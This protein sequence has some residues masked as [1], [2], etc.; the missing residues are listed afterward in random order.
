V[1]V[2]PVRALPTQEMT[3]TAEV[4][5]GEIQAIVTHDS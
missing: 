1:Y 3:A 5:L 2:E 4:P